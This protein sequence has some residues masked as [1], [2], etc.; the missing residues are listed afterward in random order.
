MDTH[1]GKKL[2]TAPCLDCGQTIKLAAQ[3]EQGDR[4]TCPHC[5]SHLEIINLE[6]PEL[7]WAFS[8]IEPDW[9]PEE[10]EWEEEDWEEE[11]WDDE[12][13]NGSGGTDS[14]Y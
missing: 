8:Q 3:L 12:D 5:G 6:P 11:E 13:W 9:D 4:L 2:A 14:D 10:E 1:L 7:D